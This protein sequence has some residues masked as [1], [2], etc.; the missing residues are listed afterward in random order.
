MNSTI[1]PRRSPASLT[2]SAIAIA[3]LIPLACS[4]GK[5]FVPVSGKITYQGKPVE[6]GTVTFISTTPG[7]RNATGMIG[8]GGYYTLQ[9]DEPKDGALPGPYNVTIFARDEVILDYIPKKPVPPKYLV[10]AKYEKPDTSGLTATVTGGSN[11]I[12]FDLA[13]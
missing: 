5:G 7:G 2:L 13:D 9:T 10:P 12:D 4:N 11:S 3:T 1:P 8:S 6:Q